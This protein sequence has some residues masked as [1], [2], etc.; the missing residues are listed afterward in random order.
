MNCR[1]CGAGTESGVIY[2][3]D[4]GMALCLRCEMDTPPKVGRAEFDRVYWGSGFANVPESTRREFYDDYRTSTLR[5]KSYI[6]ATTKG[7]E[8]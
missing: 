3:S 5:L 4:H 1:I 2:S 8:L 6:A 7:D